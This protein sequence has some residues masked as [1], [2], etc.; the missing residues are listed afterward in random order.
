[1]GVPDLGP[2]LPHPPLALL[3]LL[4]PLLVEDDLVLQPLGQLVL[5][6]LEG[7]HQ[8]AL[9]VLE[10]GEAAFD[11]GLV[12]ALGAGLAASLTEP[13]LLVYAL[14]VEQAQLLLLA[15]DGLLAQLELID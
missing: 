4:L 12:V 8:L 3:N 14:L 7:A 2:Q 13:L 6:S 9:F 1:M 11:G 15:V 5:F 10:L